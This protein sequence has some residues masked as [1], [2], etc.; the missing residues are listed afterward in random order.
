MKDLRKR[1]DDF[2]RRASHS[3][4]T[5]LKHQ[6]TESRYIPVHEFG[7]DSCDAWWEVQ[8]DVCLLQVW[9]TERD[10]Y[11][12]SGFFARRSEHEPHFLNLVAIV[13]QKPITQEFLEEIM[14]ELVSI[15]IPGEAEA[16]GHSLM[17]LSPKMG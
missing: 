6:K 14:N 15:G 13:P 3:P 16:R 5:V 1:L 2:N 4:D 9:P 12:R 7:Q 8:N 11:N 17:E 10:T